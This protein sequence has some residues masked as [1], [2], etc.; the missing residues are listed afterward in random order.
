MQIGNYL[1]S[2]LFVLL[3]S[4]A[5]AMAPVHEARAAIV[6]WIQCENVYGTV[7]LD[8]G[9]SYIYPDVACYEYSYN[10]GDTYDPVDDSY[11]G[12]SAGTQSAIC[13]WLASTKPQGCDNPVASPATYDYAF[14]A[15]PSGS[16][17]KF[18][19]GYANSG[20]SY[21]IARN[22]VKAALTTQTKDS[23]NAFKSLDATTSELLP[24][25]SRACELQAEFGTSP[26]A[27][28]LCAQAYGRL[29]QEAGNPSVADDFRDWLIVNGIDLDA[30]ANG[31]TASL[32]VI[33]GLFAPENSLKI[34]HDKVIEGQ[35]CYLWWQ[36][37][38]N[39]HCGA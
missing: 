28:T 7:T 39:N 37:A 26:T 18:L 24:K 34:K 27:E 5:G 1:R 36:Q 4:F 12:P 22:L 15:M 25:V 8:D 23:V 2:A 32:S 13:D 21:I 31:F 38:S 30:S 35:K 19:I 14:N 11:G 29:Q 33:I 3:L 16:G 17:L 9:T 10:D 6:S 20:S